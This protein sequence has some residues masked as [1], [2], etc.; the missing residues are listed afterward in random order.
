[1]SIDYLITEGPQLAK[2]VMG[3]KWAVLDVETDGLNIITSPLLGFS[4]FTDKGLGYVPTVQYHLHSS[5][6]PQPAFDAGILKGLLLHLFRSI[7]CFGYN[8]KYDLHFLSRITGE[9]P[10]Y[11]VDVMVGMWLLHEEGDMALKKNASSLAGYELP[12]FKDLLDKAQN[13]LGE[14]TRLMREAYVQMQKG[15][16]RKVTDARKEVCSIYPIPRATPADIYMEDLVPYCIKDSVYTMYIWQQV[17]RPALERDGLLSYFYTYEMPFLK[18]LYEM[19]ENGIAIDVPTLEAA[20]CE[21][22]EELAKKEADIHGVVGYGINPSSTP[23]LQRYLFDEA[24]YEP[25]DRVSKKTGLPSLDERALILLRDK[26]SEDTPLFN[27]LI[28]Y[29][30]TLKQLSFAQGIPLSAFDGLVHTSFKRVGTTTGR[31]ASSDPNLQQIP[32]SGLMRKAFIPEGKDEVIVCADLSQAELRVLADRCQDP[33]LIAAYLKEN[34]DLHKE[35]MERLGFAD[36]KGGRTLAKNI[37][38]G[39]PYGVG[40]KGYWEA[41]RFKANIDRPL[42]LCKQDIDESYK[43]YA[44]I[45]PWKTRVVAEAKRKG[46]VT[47]RLGRRRHAD[48]N[49]DDYGLRS[50]REREVVNSLIQGDV[51]DIMLVAM[52][53][54]S[55]LNLYRE[56]GAKLRLQVHDELVLTAPRENAEAVIEVVKRVMSTAMPNMRVPLTASAGYAD[57]WGEVDK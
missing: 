17:V 52:V 35:T 23:Q 50:Y 2:L 3:A 56:F 19:E 27:M 30:D 57:N 43:L 46:Y 7:P 5:P 20:S 41:L 18:V 31:L 38:F 26:Y 42:E 1:M 14:D 37:N 15:M 40:A 39:I 22:K 45:K 16:G 21:I 55:K 44:E 11:P 28:D 8:I 6:L 25:T 36:L 12:D 10:K 54:L 13:R 29:R 34:A 33:N 4:I 48:L 53:N 47:S 32:R 51:A 9:L 24:G 49:V